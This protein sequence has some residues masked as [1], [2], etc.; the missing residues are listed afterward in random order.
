MC[1]HATHTSFSGKCE[2]GL[3]A[4]PNRAAPVFNV[5]VTP[6]GWCEA[7]VPHVNEARLPVWHAHLVTAAVRRWHDGELHSDVK[8]EK[9]QLTLWNIGS[10][11][12]TRSSRQRV[13]H[14]FI[15]RT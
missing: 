9:K 3:G 15:K 8:E 6:S 10:A 12:E 13:E 5:R 7:H 11:V 2:P 4:R 14:T 1:I